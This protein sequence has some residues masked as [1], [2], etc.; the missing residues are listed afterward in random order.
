MGSEGTKPEG[1]A[2]YLKKKAREEGVKCL[3][4]INASKIHCLESS[5]LYLSAVINAS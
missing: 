3:K 5:T 1:M 4:I 2:K